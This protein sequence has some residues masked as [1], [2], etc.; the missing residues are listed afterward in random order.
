MT[1]SPPP[2]IF[3]R[4]PDYAEPSWGVGLLYH[5]VRVLRE[6]GFD[7][8]VLHRQAPF[9]LDWLDLDVAVDYL[10]RAP[11]GRGDDVVVVPEVLAAEAAGTLWPCRRGVFV[12]GSFLILAGH[13]AGHDRAFRYPDL[14]YEFALAVLPHVAEVVERHFGLPA[15]VVPP[16]IA[17]YFLR[18]EEE[19]RSR[20]RRRLVLLAVKKEYRQAGFPDYDI[21]TRLFRRH[22]EEERPLWRLEELAGLGHREV[23]AR[24]AE[25][26]LLVNLNSHEAFNSTVPEAMA[27]GCVPICY[28][29][30]G[31]RDF[32]APGSAFVFPNH[33][34]YA[35]AEETFRAMAACD[36]GLP[37]IEAMR[38]RARAAVRRFE[39]EETRRALVE[40]FTG[41]LGGA[42]ERRP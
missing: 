30:V 18:S 15:R 42:A 17:P 37:E 20:P 29:A 38:L 21:F 33:H 13:G 39:G 7:A 9:R 24:M 10:D 1:S 23:A 22:V 5:H 31:G 35:L 8:R 6:A 41:L 16:A 25:A 28:E 12:Q 40:T 19:I 36:Q 26:A 34:V 2:R 32:L 14:G 4:V 27:A 3:Y 11:A